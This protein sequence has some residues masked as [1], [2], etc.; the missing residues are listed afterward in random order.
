MD[1]HAL[2]QGDRM[3]DKLDARGGLEKL[4]G[5]WLFTHS[6]DDRIDIVVLAEFD[7]DDPNPPLRVLA[8]IQFT[9]RSFR[10]LARREFDRL[11]TDDPF[12][13][14]G[15]A[16]RAAELDLVNWLREQVAAHGYIPPAR[17]TL[18]IV[19]ESSMS[20]CRRFSPSPVVSAH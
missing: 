19:S 1:F 15:P 8:G 20:C 16:N 18:M 9:R 14:V 6:L 12:L 11:V 2:G 4:D 7:R 5:F 13:H 10:I 17:M 3:A